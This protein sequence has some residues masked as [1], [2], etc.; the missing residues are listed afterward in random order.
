[1]PV[2]CI[3]R[4]NRSRRREFSERDA[5]RIICRV[6]ANGGT[7][8]E[9]IAQQRTICGDGRQ[10]RRT[11]AQAIAEQA[12]ELADAN[13]RTLEGLAAFLE[14]AATLV[15]LIRRIGRTPATIP[16]WAASTVV[17]TEINAQLQQI[18]VQQAANRE[19]MAIIQRE[20]A[21]DAAFALR[22]GAR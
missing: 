10:R 2:V 18:R 17:R 14:L 20:A 9:I 19:A 16:L 4:P 13:D 7:L 6:I 5:A 11:A 1:M 8:A 15:G 12:Q 3:A 21:N 22:A